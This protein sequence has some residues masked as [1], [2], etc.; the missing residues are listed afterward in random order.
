MSVNRILVERMEVLEQKHG[1]EISTTAYLEYNEFDEQYEIKIIGEIISSRLEYDLSI[2][3]SLYN[4]IGEII[5]TESAY[6]DSDTFE[7]IEAFSELVSIPKGEQVG[8]VRVYP[9]QT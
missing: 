5:G 1:V 8:K 4:T 7:G 9:K 6:I 3:I 2:I